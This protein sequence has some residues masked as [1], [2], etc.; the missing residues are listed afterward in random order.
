MRPRP[1]PALVISVLVAGCGATAPGAPSPTAPVGTPMEG[2]A[3]TEAP[4]RSATTDPSAEASAS[5]LHT[6][7]PTAAEDVPGY[8]GGSDR[9]GVMPGPGPVA[10]PAIRWAFQ[11]SAPIGS[12]P[13][14]VGGRVFLVVADGT[15]VSLDLATGVPGWTA[16]LGVGA[17]GSPAVSGDLLLVGAD[18]GA[19]ALAI[20]T[21]EPRWAQAAPGVV[22]G[23]PALIGGIAL[24]ASTGG[25]AVGLDAATGKVRWSVPLGA[26]NDTSVATADS[27]AVVGMTDGAAVALD[28]TTGAVKWRTTVD[29]GARIGTPAIADG[30]V[31]LASLDEGA[32]DTRH[33]TTLDLATGRVIWRFSSPGDRPSYTPAVADGVAI[34]EGETGVITALDEASGRVRWQASEPGVLEML[35]T[36]VGDTMYGAGNGTFAFALDAGAGRERWRLPIKGVP[37]APAITGGLELMPTNTGLLYAIGGVVP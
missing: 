34:T 20:D 18:D 16:H 21:G 4:G 10:D 28:P 22:R 11:A 37:Y 25:Q 23:A 32:P 13:A 24:F 31:L 15:V 26:P 33:I 14:V 3:T 29:A 7:D 19:H 17:H 12:Q 35:P 2:Q 9:L 8:R 5:P 1:F 6:S 36:L 30:R 27:T